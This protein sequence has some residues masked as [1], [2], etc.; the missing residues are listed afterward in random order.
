MHLLVS[1]DNALYKATL[2]LADLGTEMEGILN[3]A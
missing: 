1:I 3:K 2:D